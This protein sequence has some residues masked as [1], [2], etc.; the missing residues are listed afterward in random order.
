MILF[1]SAQTAPRKRKTRGLFSVLTLTTDKGRDI[2]VRS[3]SQ[4]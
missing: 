2:T 4:K 3:V 1:G